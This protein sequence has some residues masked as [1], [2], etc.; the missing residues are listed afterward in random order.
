MKMGLE[1][2]SLAADSSRFPVLLLLSASSGVARVGCSPAHPV[3]HLSVYFPMESTST[4]EY[5]LMLGKTEGRRRRGDR[6]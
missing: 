3:P 1:C 2:C 5:T 6:G 4:P